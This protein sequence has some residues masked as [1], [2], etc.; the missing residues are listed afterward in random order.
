MEAQASVL[1]AS[2]ISRILP[3]TG[4]W[5]SLANAGPLL[6]VSLAN[7][8]PWLAV[9]LANAGPWL[10]ISLAN[11]GPWLARPAA[12]HCSAPTEPW[13]PEKLTE[14]LSTLATETC[15]RQAKEGDPQGII[16]LNFVIC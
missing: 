11:A 4:P 8:S 15:D 2:S 10:A 9:S 7:A 13:T 5:I 3:K 14:H 6:A 16:V 1:Q 12:G